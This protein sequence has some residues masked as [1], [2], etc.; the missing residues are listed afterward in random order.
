MEEREELDWWK[1]LVLGTR[2]VFFSRSSPICLTTHLG[3]E[4]FVDRGGEKS[5]SPNFFLESVSNNISVKKGSCKEAFSLS[6]RG[7]NEYFS[8]ERGK[9]P[10]VFDATFFF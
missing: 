6:S 5:F 4:N 9:K 7:P 3:L 10:G 1:K 8:E 2:V